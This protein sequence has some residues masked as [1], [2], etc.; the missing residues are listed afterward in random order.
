MRLASLDKPFAV[1]CI[2]RFDNEHEFVNKAKWP[3]ARQ[4]CLLMV[5]APER[6]DLRAYIHHT[7]PAAPNRITQ[8]E[9]DAYLET[10]PCQS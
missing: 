8:S 6:Y 10:M 4:L 1:L 3:E 9:V 2:C 5:K 7:S